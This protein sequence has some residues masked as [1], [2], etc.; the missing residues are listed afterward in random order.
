MRTQSTSS[1]HA[2]KA[3]SI[4]SVSSI[5]TLRSGSAGGGTVTPTN[6]PDG[7]TVEGMYNLGKHSIAYYSI[8]GGNG[9]NA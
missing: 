2:S 5:S 8:F 4:S 9:H 1:A 3:S 6:I 7:M